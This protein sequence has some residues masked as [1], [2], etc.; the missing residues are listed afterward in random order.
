MVKD[1]PQNQPSIK[2]RRKNTSA[3]ENDGEIDVY[4]VSGII[5]FNFTLLTY[6]KFLRKYSILK[7]KKL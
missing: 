7:R 4:K 1:T 2:K 5:F 6:K 3:T